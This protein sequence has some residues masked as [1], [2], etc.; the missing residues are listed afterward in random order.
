MQAPNFILLYVENPPASAAFYEKLFDRAPVESSTNFSMFAL[1]SGLKIGLWR[2][3][4]VRPKP[5]S[6]PGAVE[7][8]FPIKAVE[9]VDALCADWRKLGLSIAQEP[10][11]MDFGYTFVA[12]DP[13]GHRLRAFAPTP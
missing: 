6:K 13:D 9:A 8:I 2:Q 7:V 12:L 1:D 11:A 3:D 5:T 10:T 4:E